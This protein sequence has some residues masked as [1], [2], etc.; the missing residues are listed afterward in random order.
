MK[1]K[2]LLIFMPS[3]EGGGVEKNFFLIVNDLIKKFSNITVITAH[4]SIKKRL[5]K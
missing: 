2:K 1:E 4:K 3:V 5:D